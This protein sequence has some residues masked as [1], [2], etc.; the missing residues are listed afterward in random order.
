MTLF[1]RPGMPPFIMDE[2]AH[3]PMSDGETDWLVIVT[4]EALEDKAGADEISPNW[5]LENSDFF[6]EVANYK[7]QL[8]REGEEA[9]V[10]VQSEDVKQW[11]DIR[12]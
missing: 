10:W 2:N 5:L 8:G 3:V 1:I 9:T 11:Q 6:G 4:R 12:G 7:L